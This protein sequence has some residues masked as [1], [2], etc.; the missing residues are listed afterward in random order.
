MQRIV[1]F[2]FRVKATIRQLSAE[3]ADSPQTINS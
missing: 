3:F 2:M 1:A